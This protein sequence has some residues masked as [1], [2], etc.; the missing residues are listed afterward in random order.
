MWGCAEDAFG[1]ANLLHDNGLSSGVFLAFWGVFPRSDGE[2]SSSF[3][4]RRKR[5]F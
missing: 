3:E 4:V 2:H 5:R 1:A